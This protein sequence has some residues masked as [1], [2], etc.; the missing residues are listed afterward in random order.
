MFS[1]LAAFTRAQTISVP[2]NDPQCW[3]SSDFNTNVDNFANMYYI[4]TPLM[5][6][7][8]GVS[9]IKRSQAELLQF[10][11]P[12]TA[13]GGPPPKMSLGCYPSF[14]NN[15]YYS[16]WKYD[17]ATKT[18][19]NY[20]YCLDTDCASGCAIRGM[21]T[22]P[23]DYKVPCTLMTYIDPAVNLNN[24]LV[25][26]FYRRID[27][28]CT[29]SMVYSLVIPIYKTCTKIGNYYGFST[30]S[31]N[32]LTQT[33]C[34]DNSCQKCQNSSETNYWL[35]TDKCTGTTSHN[36]TPM[37]N[38][39]SVLYVDGVAQNAT[40]NGSGASPT[41]GSSSGSSSSSISWQAVAIPTLVAV[42]VILAVV[43]L[44][45]IVKYK[46]SLQKKAVMERNA[47]RLNRLNASAPF[48][49]QP[50]EI[51]SG[52]DQETYLLYMETL[53]KN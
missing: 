20:D 16:Y 42:S 39:L 30:L 14:Q 10:S 31:G 28:S 38:F 40:N 53:D 1:I 13:T 12:T 9:P 19:S 37:Y 18:I 5:T 6:D 17:S 4:T 2:V 7:S 49:E 29:G 48:V 25:M 26:N 22:Y 3:I 52:L 43:F 51:V 27:N 23:S 46:I 32:S 36:G 44:V 21:L 34:T 8:A 47:S 33:L 45:G 50:T 11:N 15:G 24:S 35:N 41:G